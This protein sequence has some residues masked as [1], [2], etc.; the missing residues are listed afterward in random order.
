MAKSVVL[1]VEH[2]TKH[3]PQGK[4]GVFVAVDDISFSLQKGEI[5]GLLGPNGAGKTTTM[6][7]L[8]GILSSSAGTIQYFGQDFEA[9]R[10]EI[11]EK[12]NFSSTYT[13][14][15]WALTIREA[16]TYSAFLYDID[17]RPA[18]IQ[19]VSQIFRLSKLMNNEVNSLSAGQLTRLNLAKAFLNYPQVL[20]LDEPTAS[21]DPET[22][23]HIRQFILQQREQFEV[24]ILFTS[25]NM[26]EVSQVCDRVMFI[27]QGKIVAIDTPNN[28]AKQIKNA[29]L[30]L[31][32]VDGLKRIVRFCSEQGLPCQEK[33]RAVT[34]EIPEKQIASFLQLLADHKISY[35]QISIEKPDLEDYFLAMARKKEA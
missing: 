19:R 12:V 18:R 1:E 13:N 33:Q 10:E 25:H 7:M 31:V 5:L 34:V 11:L 15:P 23:D 20:L 30:E 8:L 35:D 27:N 22:A 2:L 32:V 16:L 28:L 14:L 29:K 6:Q 21:L 24:S 3:F 17:D 26:A 9:N 4:D